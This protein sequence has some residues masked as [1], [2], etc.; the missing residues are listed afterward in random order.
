MYE[1]VFLSAVVLSV[2][3]CGMPGAVNTQALRVGV[4]GGFRRAMGIEMGSIVGDTTWAVIALTGLAIVWNNDI[5]RW[6][7]G[8]LGGAML[9]Y[10]AYRGFQD[11]RRKE[12]PEANAP[13]GHTDLV[14][15]IMMSFVNPFQLAFWIGIGS[16]AIVTII[17]DPQLTDFLVFYTGYITGA[18]LWGIAYSALIGYGRRYVTAKLFRRISLVCAL[19]LLYFV[20]TL[21]WSTFV[22]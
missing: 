20:V 6:V 18:V 5:A 13:S 3:F 2:I 4:S 8:I 1:A 14:T 21:L 12:L 16:S 11:A 9:L 15:G 10:L 19:V 17:P 22:V 7:L